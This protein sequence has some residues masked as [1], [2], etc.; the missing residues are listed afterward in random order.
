[1]ME[2]KTA[3]SDPLLGIQKK[4]KNTT[5]FSKSWITLTLSVCIVTVLCLVSISSR[6]EVE[7]MNEVLQAEGDT[8]PSPRAG[9]SRRRSS[10]RSPPTV[11]T[12]LGTLEGVVLQSRAGRDYFGFYNVPYGEP[13]VGELR[14]QVGF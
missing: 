12:T 11:K 6:V 3:E 8:T 5:T 1:M 14:F 10:N 9:F 2:T 7:V 4:A 13:P